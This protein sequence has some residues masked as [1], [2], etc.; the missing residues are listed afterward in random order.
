M[1]DVILVLLKDHTIDEKQ[2]LAG[3]VVTMDQKLAPKLVKD[4]VAKYRSDFR[5]ADI[6]QEKKPK[7]KAGKTSRET[8]K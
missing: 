8:G 3:S 4:G 2:T 6:E 1:A 7:A 5:P